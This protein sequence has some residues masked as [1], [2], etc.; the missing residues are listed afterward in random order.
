MKTHSKVSFILKGI[1]IGIIAA[2]VFTTVVMLLWNWLMPAIFNLPE[3]TFWQSM[4]I[5]ILS[6]ILF[7][8]IHHGSHHFHKHNR[9]NYMK[10]RFHERMECMKANHSNLKVAEE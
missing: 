8:G 6:K 1:S 3:I 10:D 7:G 4:G 2:A 9:E 5:L